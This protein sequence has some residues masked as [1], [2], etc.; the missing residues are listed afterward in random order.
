MYIVQLKGDEAHEEE[1][2]GFEDED[3][4]WELADAFDNFDQITTDNAG[5]VISLDEQGEDRLCVWPQLRPFDTNHHKLCSPATDNH[6]FWDGSLHEP[7]LEMFL[8]WK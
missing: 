6:E 1:R 8:F 3:G 2:D 7:I 4:E 5:L